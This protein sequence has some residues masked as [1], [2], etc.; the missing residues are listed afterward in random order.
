MCYLY[1][2]IS[3]GVKSESFSFQQKTAWQKMSDVKQFRLLLYF[4]L[5]TSKITDN[6]TWPSTYTKKISLF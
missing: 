2:E 6:E 3:R 1:F 5:S 4:K